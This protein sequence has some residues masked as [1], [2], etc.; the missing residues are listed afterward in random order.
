[1]SSFPA[2]FTP[3]RLEATTTPAGLGC[4]I[5]RETKESNYSLPIQLKM[6]VEDSRSLWTYYECSYDAH[7]G[8]FRRFG[9][10]RDKV[11]TRFGKLF[12]REVY[13][14]Q[15]DRFDTGL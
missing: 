6:S 10:D 4:S 7:Q 8:L 15:I 5:W 1:L 9:V 14:H 2:A 13:F 12:Y 3:A 11:W